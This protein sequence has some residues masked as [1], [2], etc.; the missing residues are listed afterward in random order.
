M[1]KTPFKIAIFSLLLLVGACSSDDD[2]NTT[3]ETTEFRVTISNNIN[4]LNAVQFGSG[5]L[6]NTGDTFEV[7]FQAV[8]GTYLSFANMFVQSNDWF[9]GSQESGILLWE[10]GTPRTGEITSLVN[11]YDA[12]TEEEEDFLN[13]ISAEGS[14]NIPPNQSG[15]NTGPADDD[16]TV[17][18]AGRNITAYLTADL[19]YNEMTRYFTL[20]IT[21]ANREGL[22]NP[23]WVSPGF[24]V[25][26]TQ[27]NAM[28]ELGMSLPENGFESLAEDGMNVA[29]NDWFNEVGTGEA[30]LRIAS[31]L[32]P[33]APGVAYTF[34]DQDPLFT[35]GE[36]ARANSGL[37]ELAEDGNNAVALAYLT[38]NGI[39][40]VANT[41]TT[42]VGPGGSLTFT[43][44]ASPGE[45]FSFATMLVQSNDW[46]ISFNN[47]GVEL[48]N[49]DGTP[50]SGTEYS[51]E[52]YLFD[53]GTEVDQEVGFGA[54][55][56]P[57]Q[58]AAN[59][60]AADPDT[61]IRRVAEIDDVQFGKGVT[62]SSPGVVAIEDARGG[63]NFITVNI[64]P[65]N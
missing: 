5:P 19:S 38:A 3:E 11:V 57:R 64:E 48:F 54:D 60:G 32:S 12:G 27:P 35:Q 65:L 40:A 6:M 50:K 59:T 53:A 2:Q 43:F 58:G 55:Q 10:N 1:K 29:L 31:S 13:D 37:E 63:Y 17:R 28:Y 61:S 46:F 18:S 14:P 9:F 7:N 22:V 16:T 62:S 8:P 52:S 4:Y 25:L 21:K 42:N 33:F 15:P 41:E 24:L 56:A 47:N 23:G 44:S 39:N 45:K 36:A 26:H 30:P 20:T 49:E 51:V 34:T